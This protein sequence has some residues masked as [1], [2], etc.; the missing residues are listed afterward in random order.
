[1]DLCN[2]LGFEPSEFLGCP[3]SS[4]QAPPAPP[5]PDSP[6]RQSAAQ[7]DRAIACFYS[8]IYSG[9]GQPQPLRP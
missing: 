4:L 9:Q 6:M 2:F 5:S 7:L 3:E 8:W 1:S